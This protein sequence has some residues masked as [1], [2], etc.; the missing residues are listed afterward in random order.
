MM[1]RPITRTVN[2]AVSMRSSSIYLFGYKGKLS[3][4]L[5]IDN[6]KRFPEDDFIFA[7]LIKV[8][9]TRFLIIADF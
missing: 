1:N 5:I 6:C 7:R 4:I 8:A 2:A 9:D 3:R